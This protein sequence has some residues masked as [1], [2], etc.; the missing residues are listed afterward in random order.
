MNYNQFTQVPGY[1][2]QELRHQLEKD[3]KT[4]MESYFMYENTIGECVERMNEAMNPD[5][6]KKYSQKDIEM[7]VSQLREMQADVKAKF[8]QS[9]GT[10]DELQAKVTKKTKSKKSPV[11]SNTVTKKTQKTTKKEPVQVKSATANTKPEAVRQ[12]DPVNAF[13]EA[14]AFEPSWMSR[15]FSAAFDV[16]PLPSRGECY[17]QN[18]K[19]IA[20]SYL[21]AND[22][23]MIV[24]PN[25]YRDGMIMDYLLNAKIRNENI[26]PD[27]LLD[28]DRDAIIL[29]LRATGYGTDYPITVTDINT[30]MD[31][32]TTLDLTK[33]KHKPFNLT[34]DEN[35]YFDFV[36]PMSKD[37][38]KFRFL[39][40]GDIKRIEQIDKEENVAVKQEKLNEICDTLNSFIESDD[41]ADRDLKLKLY[42]AKRNIKKWADSLNVDDALGYTHKLTNRLELSIVS[43]NGNTNREYISDYVLNLNPRDA[44]SLRRYINENEPGLDF[45]VEVEKPE[46]LG[47]G[48]MPVFLS[49]DE[50]IFLNIA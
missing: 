40:H 39:T 1:D 35:G 25:L 34:G 2:D 46:S 27:D 16:I 7:K 6:S 33:I 42:E 23:N 8:I 24:S 15:D 47:G 14:P 37:K 28:G 22:E 17:S 26:D 18:L 9:G 20:V 44:L 43:V 13:Q 3:R 36:M 10:E 45:N 4:F 32:E 5:G 29:W 38:I 49:L 21:T 41:T 31:F 50:Y 30:G 12:E 11:S 48:S 19:N